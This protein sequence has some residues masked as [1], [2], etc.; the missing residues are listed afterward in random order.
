ME[1]PTGL[2]TTLRYSN[3]KQIVTS[4]GDTEEFDVTAGVLQGDT[5]APFLFIV[6][7]DYSLLLITEVVHITDKRQM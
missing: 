6:V 7:R 3:T 4:D 1:S 5:L 2:S